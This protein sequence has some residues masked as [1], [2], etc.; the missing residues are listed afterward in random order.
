MRA[1]IYASFFAVFSMKFAASS[2]PIGPEIIIFFFK[3]SKLAAQI[4]EMDEMV[5]FLT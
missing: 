2:K 3:K 1:F 4:K 5:D